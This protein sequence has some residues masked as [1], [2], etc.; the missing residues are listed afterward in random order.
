MPREASSP[1]LLTGAAASAA[2]PPR[3]S[4]GFAS[5]P[6]SPALSLSLGSPHARSP[7]APRRDC[8]SRSPRQRCTDPQHPAHT[9]PRVCAGCRDEA[10]QQAPYQHP[11]LL[12]FLL[13]LL[14][15]RALALATEGSPGC[16]QRLSGTLAH[17]GCPPSPAPRA[18]GTRY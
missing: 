9:H 17:P 7:A 8:R 5:L 6:L 3:T 1:P 16:R 15:Q 2:S 13:L 4:S 14:S 12:L 10:T 18:G 11:P